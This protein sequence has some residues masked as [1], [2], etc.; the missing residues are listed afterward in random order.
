MENFARQEEEKHAEQAAPKLQ[1]IMIDCESGSKDTY[2]SLDQFQEISNMLAD[3]AVCKVLK[4]NEQ[5][6]VH[7]FE[8]ILEESLMHGMPTILQINA[9]SHTDDGILF[10]DTRMSPKQMAA[11]I[12]A[13]TQTYRHNL[14]AI[15]L[16]VPD[17]RL[18]FY[19]RASLD[20]RFYMQDSLNFDVSQYMQESDFATNVQSLHHLATC[21]V[22]KVPR[23]DEPDPAYTEGM[24]IIKEECKK[25]IDI[26]EQ[27]TP[28][29]IKQLMNIYLPRA[30]GVADE[31]KPYLA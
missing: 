18:L 17:A 12:E 10:N 7:D 13:A 25:I 24:E 4:L 27:T 30:T 26:L 6:N 14:K 20:F 8:Q 28:W 23:K 29:D 15:I 5:A 9:E 22:Q 19:M 21:F 1:I 2:S 11:S 3:T 16:N 31:D